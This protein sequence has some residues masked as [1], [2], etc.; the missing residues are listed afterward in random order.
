LVGTRRV[1]ACAAFGAARACIGAAF[2]ARTAVAPRVAR[3]V[4]THIAIS[5]AVAVP[6]ATAAVAIVTCIAML[7]P[8]AW[9]GCRRGGSGNVAR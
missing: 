5:I 6:I 9:R 3:S 4:A 8:V 2:T 7:R 1:A